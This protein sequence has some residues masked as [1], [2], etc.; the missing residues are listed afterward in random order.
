ML[1]FLLSESLR[2]IGIHF[3]GVVKTAT[4]TSYAFPTL[5]FTTWTWVQQKLVIINEDYDSVFAVAIM[6]LNNN[7]LFFVGNS[8]PVT[9]ED[10][11]Y[12]GRWRQEVEHSD[13]MD[14]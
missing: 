12:H 8:E 5:Q 14:P 10:P 1:L 4:K 9:D 11:L 6:C 2:K 13:N 3:V 7:R